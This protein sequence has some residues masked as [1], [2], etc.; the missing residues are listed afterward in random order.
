MLPRSPLVIP[1]WCCN[2]RKAKTIS[3]LL[4]LPSLL[5]QLQ[6]L[7]NPTDTL[8]PT[9]RLRADRKLHSSVSATDHSTGIF[10]LKMQNDGN[11]VQYPV[12]TSDI[13]AFAYWTSGTVGEED[14]VTLNL[15]RDDSS[16]SAQ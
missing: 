14:N 16:L 13:A 5:L 9:Q 2:L 12:R 3:F 10:R 8:L 15:D 1:L 6:S 4:L 11:L 7:D